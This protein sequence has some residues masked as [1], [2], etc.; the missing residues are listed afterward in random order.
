MQTFQVRCLACRSEISGFICA[1]HQPEAKGLELVLC[2]VGL[3]ASR[4]STVDGQQHALQLCKQDGSNSY[5]I[6]EA[7]HELTNA[8]IHMQVIAY[9][10]YT[11][12]AEHAPLQI[13]KVFDHLCGQP[14]QLLHRSILILRN[15]R[16]TGQLAVIAQDQVS[17]LWQLAQ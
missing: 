8:W 16:H 17:D 7:L 1:Q 10:G 6:P 5:L 2:I 11:N 12:T 9:L 3:L 13:L 4:I 15:S 14:Y